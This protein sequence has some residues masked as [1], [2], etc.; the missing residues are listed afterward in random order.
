MCRPLI[1]SKLLQSVLSRSDGS[2]HTKDTR[3][4]EA[5]VLG[6]KFK[7]EGLHTGWYLYQSATI[8]QEKENRTVSIYYHT[9]RYNERK[10]EMTR[11]YKGKTEIIHLFLTI[12]MN[13]K[14]VMI[15]FSES[16]SRCIVIRQM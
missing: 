9:K 6:F 14:L 15:L 12:Q 3:E 16:P 7:K 11:N 8:K 4:E 1:S 2:K 5:K 13:D 10:N